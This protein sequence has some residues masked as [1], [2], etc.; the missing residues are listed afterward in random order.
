MSVSAI[1]KRVNGLI[2]LGALHGFITRPSMIAMKFI[3]IRMWGISSAKSMSETTKILGQHENVESVGVG[4]GKFINIIGHLRDISEL[5]S[6]SSFVANTA[7]ISNPIIGI[8]NYDY[9]TVPEP[10]TSLDF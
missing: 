8:V 4:G 3:W 6:F 10:L 7:K 9:V 2:E 5:Q 1:H